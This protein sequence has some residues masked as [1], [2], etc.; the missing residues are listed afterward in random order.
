MEP[1][2]GVW[3]Q[4]V[5]RRVPPG[6][7][8]GKLEFEPLQDT[9]PNRYALE[10]DDSEDDVTLN[11]YPNASKQLKKPKVTYNIDFVWNED[12]STV[13]GNQT[14]VALGEA[15]LIWASGTSLD[16]PRAQ[17]RLNEDSVASVYCLQP[18][19]DGVGV[20][21]VVLQYQLPIDAMHL[22]ASVVLSTLR[23]KSV[24]VVDEYSHPAYISSERTPPLDP[25]IRYLQTQ[26]S[27]FKPLAATAS[28]QTPNLLLSPSA[29][30]LSILEME[31][32]PGLLV[33]LPLPHIPHPPPSTTTP[34][35]LSVHWPESQIKV[36]HSAIV[37]SGNWVWDARLAKNAGRL[38]VTKKAKRR[39]SDSM[40]MY[41]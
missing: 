35:R 16:A 38:T 2:P 26:K 25:P 15:G 17:V 29:S 36:L 40:N 7:H 28:F 31:E 19:K 23:P 41:I 6:P 9:T 27:S 20:T 39:L 22:F 24:V 10:S 12:A 18:N 33:L 37:K 13:S 4:G 32:K 21:V 34:L 11:T 5:K 8:H 14:Y 1:A 3:W 30:F